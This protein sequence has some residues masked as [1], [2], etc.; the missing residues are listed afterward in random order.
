MS[1]GLVLGL[2]P[3]V[4]SAHGASAL[5]KSPRFK[6]ISTEFT[7]STIKSGLSAIT[8]RSCTPSDRG[9]TW[10]IQS[11]PTRSSLF[12]V[13]FRQPVKRLDQRQLRHRA[14]HDGRRQKLARAAAGTTEHLFAAALAERELTVGWSVAGARLVQT[15]RW[16]SLL[17][18]LDPYRAILL[19]AAINFINATR[20]WMV[21][22]FG[23]IFQRTDG[24]K[25]WVKQ[26]SPVEVSFYSGA[27]QK[28]VR[29]AIHG[30][31]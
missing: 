14:A 3:P 18:H 16:R 31:D 23:V 20:G 6:R 9:K 4:F 12:N 10:E 11:S 22:E 7:S 17:E 28:F 30:A 2:A 15:E 5:R 21:G 24:G 19:S 13:R 1:A 27:S 29:A 8:G 26:K 25:S